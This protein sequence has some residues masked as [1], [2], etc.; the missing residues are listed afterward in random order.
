MIE[1]RKGFSVFVVWLIAIVKQFC[2]YNIKKM[3][4]IISKNPFTMKINGEFEFISNTDLD[5]KIKKAH[6][7]FL[8]HSKRRVQ[9]RADMIGNLGN[10][11][12][13]NKKQLS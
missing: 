9:E 11:I 13:K 6:E 7:A 10:T 1:I 2:V 4:K 5:S 8:I 12:E 3:R